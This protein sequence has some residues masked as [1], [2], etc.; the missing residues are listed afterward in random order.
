MYIIVFT[1]SRLYIYLCQ[2]NSTHN[3]TSNFLKTYSTVVRPPRRSKCVCIPSNKTQ[4]EALFKYIHFTIVT[5]RSRKW[6]VLYQS[7]DKICIHISWVR[8]EF[9]WNWKTWEKV[10]VGSF[11]RL[12]STFSWTQVQRNLKG[13][14]C[15]RRTIWRNKYHDTETFCTFYRLRNSQD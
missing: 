5:Y 1:R 9:D 4:W 8:Q 14:F 11:C 10:S 13:R 3:F 6:C 12:E 7:S 15:V 2:V